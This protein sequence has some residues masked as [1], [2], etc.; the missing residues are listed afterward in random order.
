MRVFLTGGTGL[1]GSHLAE[2]LTSSGHHVVALHRPGSETGHLRGLG[3]TLVSG[4]VTASADMLAGAMAGCSHVV[5]GAA[6]VYAG[7]GWDVIR[8]VNVDATRTVLTAAA[9]AGVDH[10]LHV[11]SVAVYGTVEGTID[12]TAPVDAPVP[13]AD[14]Y[15]RSKRMAEREA[16]DVE[17]ESG[18]P[19][20][21]ARPSAVYGERDRLMVPALA[22]ILRRPVVPVFGTGRNTLPVVYA[23]N[24]ASAMR[25]MLEAGE[26]SRDATY[27]VG[28]DHPLTQRA[29]FD[30]LARGLGRAPTFV[31]VPAAAVRAGV[32]ILTGL[33]VST[34]GAAHLPLERVARLALG[35]NPYPS[36]RVRERLGWTP[37]HGH[38]RALERSGRWYA[39]EH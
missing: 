34:P 33:G 16:R 25:L 30:G 37:V 5:H 28:L 1:L 2:E 36:R 8:S 31:P 17:H 15:A 32:G 11:S 13:A 19:V 12:E 24:V 7:G 26:G 14:F 39:N 10:A 6:L 29:L 21:I 23:G 4:D 9:R 3:C 20:T 38:D 35:E 18:L 22:D 27:D